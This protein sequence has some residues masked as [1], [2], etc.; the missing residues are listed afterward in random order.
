VGQD[1]DAREAKSQAQRMLRKMDTVEQVLHPETAT[2]RGVAA[3]FAG[4]W[5]D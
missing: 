4:E 1:A 5:P 2:F 3:T